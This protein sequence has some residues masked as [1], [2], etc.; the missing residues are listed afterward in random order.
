[1]K[2]TVV[3]PM[4]FGA[5]GDGIKDDSRAVIA[6]VEHAHARGVG[7]VLFPPG[8]YLLAGGESVRLYGDTLYRMDG[9]RFIIRHDTAELFY[10]FESENP[11]NITVTGGEIVGDPAWSRHNLAKFAAG[12]KNYINI[13][14]LRISGGA[15]QNV[16][17]D[18]FAARDLTA[19]GILVISKDENPVRRIRIENC[20]ILRASPNYADYLTETTA[21]ALACADW[22]TRA[23]IFVKNAFDVEIT[24]CKAVESHCDGITLQK[25]ENALVLDSSAT[26]QHMGGIV[27]IGGRDIVV[28]NCSATGNG[29]RGFTVEAQC[30]NSVL[31]QCTAAG[32]GREGCWIDRGCRNITLVDLTFAENGRKSDMAS[33]TTYP[34][35]KTAHIRITK[36]RTGQKNADIKISGCRFA[37]QNQRCSVEVEPDSLEGCPVVIAGCWFEVL[38]QAGAAYPA[39]EHVEFLGHADAEAGD[40]ELIENAGI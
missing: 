5:A 18:G 26:A 22:D 13:G 39:R 1:M 7:E 4:D 32:N 23:N 37:T 40:V 11:R 9:A 35:N 14:G 27:L 31:T 2:Q 6:A 36:G 15:T 21:G 33:N 17:I 3:T 30:Q 24:G 38:A 12:T 25:C 16:C 20:E 29:S 19:A 28:K 8:D 10:A 34:G